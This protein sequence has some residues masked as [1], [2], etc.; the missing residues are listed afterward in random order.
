MCYPG[1]PE[2]ILR[3]LG[4]IRILILVRDPIKRAASQYW[5]NRRSLKE[6]LNFDRVFRYQP[7]TMFSAGYFSGVYIKYIDKYIDLFDLKMSK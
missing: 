2:K 7:S 1:V 4:T 5:D 3:D 6:P